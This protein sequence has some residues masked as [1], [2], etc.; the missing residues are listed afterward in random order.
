MSYYPTSQTDS[1][2]RDYIMGD[3]LRNHSIWVNRFYHLL[4]LS[5]LNKSTLKLSVRDITTNHWTKWEDLYKCHWSDDLL[6]GAYDLH[7]E[8]LYNEVVIESDYPDYVDNYDATRIIGAILEK[9]GF[10]PHYYYSGSK[11]IHCHVYLD[12]AQ[13]GKVDQILQN[14][15]MQK[16]KTGNRFRKEFIEFVR[17]LMIRCWDTG[18]REFDEQLIHS[19]HLIRAEQSKNKRG[20]KTFLGYTYKDLSFVPK[21]CNEV[22]RIYPVI[23]KIKISTDYDAQNLVEEFWN[24]IVIKDKKNKVKRRESALSRWSNPD[25]KEQLR[26]CVGFILSDKFKTANDGYKR[27]MFILINELKRFN[28]TEDTIAQ[29]YDWNHRMNY[30]LTNEMINYHM[31][32]K[33]YNLS[34]NYIHTFLETLG[35]NDVAALCKGKVYK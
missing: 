22:N 19:S 2:G 10:I 3:P 29:L 15:I 23:G 20:Y 8:V 7:R 14:M 13:L 35:F 18:I 34:C 33:E 4:K 25:A 17:G 26:Y 21:I 9:K 27:A 24:S 16:Y 1:I 12:F 31:K 30:P 5:N 32:S 28:N 6:R 11:S